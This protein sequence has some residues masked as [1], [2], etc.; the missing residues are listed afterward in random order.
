MA[1][2]GKYQSKYSGA[3]IEQVIESLPNYPSKEQIEEDL[4]KKQDLLKSGE[5]IKTIN[6]ESILGAGNIEIAGGGGGNANVIQVAT[7]SELPNVGG[8]VHTVYFVKDESATYRFDDEKLVYICV[9]R[10]YDNIKIINGGTAST[11]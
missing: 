5:N 4:A 3:Q 1:T 2:I 10:D 8:S 9:G 11:E 6:G 7:K